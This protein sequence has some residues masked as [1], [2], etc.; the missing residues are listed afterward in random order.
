VR[1]FEIDG[2]VAALGFKEAPPATD[3]QQIAIEFLLE[4]ETAMRDGEM[5]GMTWPHVHRKKVH[6][7]EGTTKNG[8]ARDVA[9]SQRARQLI[10]YMRGIDPVRVFTVAPATRDT[11]FR[12]ARERAGLAGFTFHDGRSEGLSRLAK[13][14]DILKLARMTGHRDLNSLMIYYHDRAEDVADELDSGLLARLKPG[15]NLRGDVARV[16]A[17][18]RQHPDWLREVG[19]RGDDVDDVVSLVLGIAGDLIEA[20]QLPAAKG[21]E[22]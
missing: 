6:L 7:P 14:L 3:E 18:L 20:P 4:I 2:M 9:L 10:D 1:Q 22:A 12:E 15:H 13:R 11:L 16:A 19:L 5:L 8:D 21:D 17:A